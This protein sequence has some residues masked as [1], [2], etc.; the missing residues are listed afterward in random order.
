LQHYLTLVA[1]DQTIVIAAMPYQEFLPNDPIHKYPLYQ[2]NY[3]GVQR[4]F[5]SSHR[6]NIVCVTPPYRCIADHCTTANS[7]RAKTDLT[8]QQ[9]SIAKFPVLHVAI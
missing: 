3:S 7:P 1:N 4:G 5:D 8:Y 2:K 6:N 9:I